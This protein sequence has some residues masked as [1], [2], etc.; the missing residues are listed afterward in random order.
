MD[1]VV[2][3]HTTHGVITGEKVLLAD[4]L[5]VEVSGLPPAISA[6][7]GLCLRLQENQLEKALA[8]LGVHDIAIQGVYRQWQD[9][10]HK[11]EEKEN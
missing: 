9:T 10:Y 2:T 4:E 8:V 5:P 3:F 7:C 6:G 1:I 11:I